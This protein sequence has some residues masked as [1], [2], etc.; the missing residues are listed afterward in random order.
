[1]L[2][3]PPPQAEITNCNSSKSA[4]VVH[5][6]I[7]LVIAAESNTT[8]HLSCEPSTLG[9]SCATPA[10]AFCNPSSQMMVSHMSAPEAHNPKLTP[11]MESNTNT[12]LSCEP[13][14]LLGTS[15]AAPPA[16]VFCNPSFQMMVPQMSASKT[17]NPK[18]AP[19]TEVNTNYH[20]SCVPSKLA[21]AT[22][23]ITNYL[24]YE[25]STLGTSCSAAPA[26]S[27]ASQSFCTNNDVELSVAHFVNVNSREASLLGGQAREIPSNHALHPPCPVCSRP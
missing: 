8:N 9:I 2:A 10:A 17:C 16:A 11:A 21:A 14:A 7:T 6:P 3:C 27:F 22:E 4:H 25:P 23:S 13:S 19:A 26:A 12:N 20:Q 15:C 24:G 18:L 5:N 1:M